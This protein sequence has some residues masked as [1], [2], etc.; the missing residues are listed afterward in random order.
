MIDS[1][2]PSVPPNTGKRESLIKEKHFISLTIQFSFAFPQNCELMWKF[3]MGN[4]PMACVDMFP[5]A[6]DPWF[7][8]QLSEK[9]ARI[10]MGWLPTLSFYISSQFLRKY[11]ENLNCLICEMLLIG[12]RHPN[13]K[14]QTD[15]ICAKYS[16][17]IHAE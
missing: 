11:R 10:A 6:G 2:L 13:L 7:E 16:P 9:M 8:N 12:N 3:Q 17:L 5:V 14:T 15:S 4:Q 1:S